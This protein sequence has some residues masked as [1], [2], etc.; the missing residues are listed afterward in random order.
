LELGGRVR[1][2][3]IAKAHKG[4]LPAAHQPPG[5]GATRVEAKETYE[6]IRS[7][8]AHGQIES[9]HED[10]D[11]IECVR[12]NKRDYDLHGPYYDQPTRHRS[13]VRGRNAG[14]IKPFSHDLKKVVLLPNFMPSGIDRYDGSTNPAKWLE[15]YQLAIEAAEGDPYVMANYLPI[16]LSSSARIWLIGL[17]TGSVR[18]LSD[19]CCRLKKKTC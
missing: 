1:I 16:C 8:D 5:W 3:T 18:S 14:G 13:S 17:L 9:C 7:K 4:T 12:Y 15:V 11:H 19:F 10:R 2:P 6:T